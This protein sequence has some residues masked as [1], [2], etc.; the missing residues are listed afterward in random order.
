MTS[1]LQALKS[2]MATAVIAGF[3][4]MA[5]GLGQP[6]KAV[7]IDFES[8]SGG[9]E[10]TNQ[11]PEATF[12]SN[13]GFVIRVFN[14]PFAG[15][16]GT[17]GIDLIAPAVS[18]SGFNFFQDVFVDFTNPVN[19]LTFLAAANNSIG[20]IA[21]VDVFAT[22]AGSVNVVGDGNLN[23]ASLVDLTAFTNVTRIEIKNVTDQFGLGYDDFIFDVA[24][25]QD[26]GPTQ[27][28]EPGTLAMFGLGLAGLGYMRRK[29]AI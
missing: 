16:F 19:N 24:V 15:F 23:T 2:V 4:A 9:T 3:M 21:Q 20:N 11:F 6:A 1:D 8:L 14:A 17:S 13:S 10:V 26:P 5:A 22:L 25:T 12:S 27:V 28:P 29:R 7:V 18:G